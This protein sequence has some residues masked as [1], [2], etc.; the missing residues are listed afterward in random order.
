MSNPGRRIA[1]LI[2]RTQNPIAP[3]IVDKAYAAVN[4]LGELC[5]SIEPDKAKHEEMLDKLTSAWPE[6]ELDHILNSPQAVC[7]LCAMLAESLLGMVKGLT[8]EG[9][10]H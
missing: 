10:T 3:I 5:A 4:A 2:E 6:A 9:E 8:D 1:L 7:A